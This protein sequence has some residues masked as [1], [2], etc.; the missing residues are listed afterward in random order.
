MN[1]PIEEAARDIY[2]N[3][4][5]W[6]MIPGGQAKSEILAIL[7]KHFDAALSERDAEI[8]RLAADLES[9]KRSCGGWA[10]AY[11]RLKEKRDAEI[12]R[13]KA[14]IE[15]LERPGAVRIGEQA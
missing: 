9:A 15:W 4:L 13:L 3:M 5:R 2:R 6:C 8:E 12:E 14:R 7:R 11:D 1:N 10:K